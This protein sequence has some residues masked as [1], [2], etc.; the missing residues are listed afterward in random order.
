MSTYIHAGG[1][2]RFESFENLISGLNPLIK[3]GLLKK[4]EDDNYSAWGDEDSIID[5]DVVDFD[6]L[7]LTLPFECYRNLGLF[8]HLTLKHAI[9]GW[10][11]YYRTD[12]LNELKIWEDG[13]IEKFE[14]DE[15]ILRL[16]RSSNEIDKDVLSMDPLEFELKHDADYGDSLRKLMMDAYNFL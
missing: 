1:C 16:A 12:G 6:K 9:S 5:N 10:F 11:K 3:G 7:E 4:Q 15:S 13:K 14:T 2:I 8:I